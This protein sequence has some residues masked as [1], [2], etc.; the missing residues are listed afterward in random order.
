MVYIGI[1][2][3]LYT[4]KQNQKDYQ[5]FTQALEYRT[6]GDDSTVDIYVNRYTEANLVT[7]KNYHRKN[8]DLGY[9]IAVGIY[10]LNI[11]DASVDAHLF[12]FNINDDLSLNIQPQFMG[13]QKT[14]AL[15]LK[16]NW[17]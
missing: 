8:S 1:G 17:N 4:A 16:L 13:P 15:S 14:P 11:V 5:H 9:I 3:A 10:L 7:I 2:A 12:N 6:D